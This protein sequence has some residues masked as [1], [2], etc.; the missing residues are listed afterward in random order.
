MLEKET[1][2]ILFNP[3]RNTY[4]AS[5]FNGHYMLPTFEPGQ[6]KGQEAAQDILTH[7][8]LKGAAV[9][10]GIAFRHFSQKTEIETLYLYEVAPDFSHPELEERP[11][12]KSDL[13]HDLGILCILVYEILQNHFDTNAHA[14]HYYFNNLNQCIDFKKEIYNGLE[15]PV[16][17]R[18][19]I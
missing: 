12:T 16:S 18:N 13:Q 15:D 19:S 3:E 7:Y 8:A 14:V 10:K 2:V 17:E 4:F 5:S 6:E 1:A 11:I 9:F